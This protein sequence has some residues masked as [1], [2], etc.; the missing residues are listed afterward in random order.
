[1]KLL[2]KISQSFKSISIS[3]KAL[4]LASTLAVLSPL[5]VTSGEAKAF[6]TFSLES[7]VALNTNHYFRPLNGQPRMSL[8]RHDVRDR[9]QQFM[10]VPSPD[11]ISSRFQ[12]MSTGKCLNAHHV[13]NGGEVNVWPCNAYDPDQR[14]ELVPLWGGRFH[15]RRMG[16]N[17][18]VDAPQ[19]RNY[20]RVH[21]WE[22]MEHNPHQRWEATIN[23]PTPHPHHAVW[24][25]IR[26][27]R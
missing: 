22:C 11:G 6:V 16:T 14:F 1:M 25:S 19:F 18:C 20:G 13:W 21:L 17:L 26:N 27:H 12:Q 15:I 23:G 8:W 4:V 7:D 10:L 3:K 2:S 24:E 5:A 9:D